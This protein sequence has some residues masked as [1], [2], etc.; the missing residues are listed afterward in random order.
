MLPRRAHVI[1][2]TSL[3]S[4]GALLALPNDVA[5]QGVIYACVQQ[6]SGLVRFVADTQPCRLAE[7]R[8]AFNV[9]GP[10]GPQGPQGPAGPQGPQG[11][12][13]PAGPQG[14]TGPQG[15]QGPAGPQG[16]KGD[17]GPQGPQGSTGPQGGQGP[18][19]PQGDQGPAG[20]DGP[21][22]P[23]GPAG[24]TGP[25]GAGV[26]NVVVRSAT[27]TSVS[28]SSAFYNASVSCLPGE[29]LTGCGGFISTACSGGSVA[30]TCQLVET[31]TNSSAT[32]CFAQAFIGASIPSTFVTVQ[33]ICR[34]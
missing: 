22:G 8:V 24:P 16:V 21:A 30:N 13:G 14:A 18:A 5:A 19:G 9:A 26:A 10:Q 17:P 20:P 33:A 31:Q 23:A 11:P 7:V 6:G 4:F 15:V 28:G 25:A 34:H 12:A 1:V 3:L 27:V 29:Y 2:I 32:A